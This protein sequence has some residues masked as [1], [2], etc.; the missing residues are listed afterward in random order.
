M[1][2][3]SLTSS[4]NCWSAARRRGWRSGVDDRLKSTTRSSIDADGLHRISP[5][6]CL[7][8]AFPVNFILANR[9][10]CV[11]MAVVCN[12]GLLLPT[13]WLAL[14]HFVERVLG[15]PRSRSRIDGKRKTPMCNI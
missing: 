2:D 1:I 15:E 9:N 8:T 11:H 14:K 6:I 10:L 12:P 4:G 5:A 3:A 7:K 13:R